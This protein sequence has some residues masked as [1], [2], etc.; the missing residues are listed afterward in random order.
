MAE[1]LAPAPTPDTSPYWEGAREGRLRI[2]RCLECRR[3]YFY[4]RAFCRYCTSS[5]VE[6][7]DASGRARLVSYV[8]DARPLPG[9]EGAS[10]V[11]ALVRLDEGP[12]MLTNIVDV[13]PTPENLRLDMALTVTFTLRGDVTLPVF[14][15]A[16]EEA[17]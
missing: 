1:A 6:W 5:Y 17:A 2:Q 13:D 16:E 14:T 9:M 12:T 10:P 15:P 4:P 8:I 3:H 7:V 11:I